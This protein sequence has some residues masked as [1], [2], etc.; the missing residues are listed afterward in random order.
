MSRAYRIRVKESLRRDISASDEICSDLEILEVL[1]PEQMSELLRAE[2][3]NRGFEDAGDGK[4]V[5]KQDNGVTVTV[6]TKTGEV[7]VKAETAERVDLEVEREDWAYDD[8]GPGSQSTKKRLKEQ[9][10][11]DLE[12]KADQ[13]Q[14]RL[15]T[16]ATERLEGEMDDVRRELGPF[17]ARAKGVHAGALRA[18]RRAP[19]VNRYGGRFAARPLHFD[20]CW[21]GRQRPRRFL[22]ESHVRAIQTRKEVRAPANEVPHERGPRGGLRERR[23][24]GPEAQSHFVPPAR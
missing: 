15:Q 19:R 23:E 13:Q 20:R 18:D 7:S 22:T 16:Q 3:K 21:R 2:L 1:P 12:R 14:S 24:V 17:V 10:Q 9:A 5:R 11:K 4:V 6:D 8:V